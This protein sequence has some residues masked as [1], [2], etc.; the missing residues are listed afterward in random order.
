LDIFGC[1]HSLFKE[2]L[3][4]LVGPAFQ[5]LIRILVKIATPADKL[6]QNVF[7]KVHYQSPS[8]KRLIE[9]EVRVKEML[10]REENFSSM[11]NK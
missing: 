8:A 4:D 5:I 7:G 11:E 1:D 9:K 3:K 10:Q 6:N 2:V